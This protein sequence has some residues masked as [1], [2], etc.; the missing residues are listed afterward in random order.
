[1]LAERGAGG[2]VDQPVF[3]GHQR[4][5]ERGL[6]RVE[7]AFFGLGRRVAEFVVLDHV[8]RVPVRLVNDLVD[9]VRAVF[10][11]SPHGTPAA[12][13]VSAQERTLFLPVGASFVFEELFQPHGID[14]VDGQYAALPC[15]RC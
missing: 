3:A 6:A 9:G 12:A 11:Q 13:V 7:M 1:M 10:D 5:Q 8:D 15:R 4:W 14:R 2:L